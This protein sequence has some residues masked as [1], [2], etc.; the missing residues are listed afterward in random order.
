MT[1]KAPSTLSFNSVIKSAAWLIFSPGH[2]TTPCKEM[3]TSGFQFNPFCQ[4]NKAD[5]FYQGF[6][7]NHKDFFQKK[8]P[9]QISGNRNSEAHLSFVQ[10]ALVLEVFC[11]IPPPGFRILSGHFQTFNQSSNCAVQPVLM[12]FGCCMSQFSAQVLYESIHS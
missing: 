7:P 4:K 5:K 9:F 12:C 6:I 8:Q 3:S 10:S 2:V 1:L 11:F